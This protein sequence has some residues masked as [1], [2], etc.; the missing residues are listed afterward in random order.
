MTARPQLVFL[1]G[2][3]A[4]GKLTVAEEVAKRRRF[5]VL[6]NHVTIDAVA[7]VLPFG[8]DAFWA[9]VGRL[10]RDLVASAARQGIDLIYTYVF[11]LGDEP[12]VD[13]IA[14]AYEEAGGNVTFVQLLASADELMRRVQNESRKAHGKIRDVTTLQRVLSKHDTRALIPG[15]ESLTIDLDATTAGQAAELIVGLLDDRRGRER[16]SQSGNE[17]AG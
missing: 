6:H 2:P 5:R 3:P 12:H 13:Q 8:T 15:R 9:V 1:Y 17:V 11:A 4:V 10:R 14:A 16:G 7:T